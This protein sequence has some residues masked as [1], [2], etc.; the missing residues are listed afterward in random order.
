VIASLIGYGSAR[1]TVTLDATAETQIE[2]S[3]TPQAI[4]LGELLVQGEQAYS[5]ASS[6]TV[7]DFDLRTRPIRSSQDLLALTPG[8]V[9]AQH[10]GGGKAEQIFLRGFDNDHGTDIAISVDGM[11]VNLVSHGHGQGYADLHFLIPEVV[12]QIDVFKGPYFAEFGNLATSGSIAFATKD[13]LDA[14]LVALEGGQFDT[15]KLTTLFQIP[16]AGPHQGAYFAGQFYRS[17]GPFLSPQGFDRFNL[18]GKFH[19]HLSDRSKISFAVGGFSSAWDASGQVPDRAVRA[20][21]I[22]RFGAIDD[23][24]GGNTGRINLNLAYEAY[25]DDQ[26]LLVQTYLARYNFKL[27]S[28][29]TF[30]L[31][32][33]TNGDMIEQNDFRQLMGVN[34]ENRRT[35]ELGKLLAVAMVGGGIRSDDV[36]VALFHAP[37]RQRLETRVDSDVR[38]RSYFLWAQE[39][40]IFTPKLRLQLGL[41]GDYFTFDV[42]DRLEGLD[43]DLPHASGYKQEGI[44]SPKGSLVVSPTRELDLFA[45]FGTGFHSNDARD[46]VIGERVDLLVRTMSRS[47]LGEAAIADSLAALGFNPAQAG[48][49]TLPRAIGAELGMRTRLGSRANLG[50]AGWWLDLEREFV[51]VGDAG[52]TELS[53]RTRRVGVDIEGRVGILPWL[54][55]D[56]DVTLSE[57]T[58]R[59]APE[60]ANAIPLAPQI[61]ATGG[62]TARHASGLEG[63]LRARHVDDR[64]ANE[65]GSVVAQGYTIFDLLASCQIDRYRVSMVVENL[66][67]SE[68]NEAQFDTESRLRNETAPV[69]EIHFTPGNP[70]NMCVGVSYLF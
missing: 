67:N 64:P 49:E 2:I 68:W 57:G 24:E 48:Q 40:I 7:R 14:N 50:I 37:N 25:S 66:A 54:F 20:G 1:T 44:L 29:F 21:Q 47:G 53:G 9:T 69:S 70:R 61:T 15:A 26:E 32:D 23:L 59:D 62:L 6:H 43:S 41:R 51:Y 42:E 60:D 30:F 36:E 56:A 28:N 39:E 19:S 18:F 45:N 58:V 27:F 16:T 38:E 34:C 17:D 11:P 13:H 12:D 22:D 33:P 3:L 8:L 5:A 31:D 35:H 4:E 46:V 52:T 55:A 10:A 63:S 65:D